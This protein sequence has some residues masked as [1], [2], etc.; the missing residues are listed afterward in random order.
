MFRNL[1]NPINTGFELRMWTFK[2]LSILGRWHW[3]EPSKPYQYWDK[4]K[5]EILQNPI[6]TGCIFVPEPSKPYQYWAA[7]EYGCLQNP[8]NT[9]PSVMSKAFKTLSILGF[10]KSAYP[11][12]PYQYWGV[13]TQRTFKTLSILGKVMPLKPSKPYQYWVQPGSGSLQ[14]PINTGLSTFTQYLQNP[15]NTGDAMYDFSFKTLSILN[16]A[17]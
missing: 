17:P 3:D 1:Q 14:N 5:Q 13:L 2:T 15:I 6:N 4:F 10:S 7:P 16:S 11:S 9:G 12:K 8:I